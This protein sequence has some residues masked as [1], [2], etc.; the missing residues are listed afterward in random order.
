MVKRGDLIWMTVFLIITSFLVVPNLRTQFIMTTTNHPY[1]MGFAKFAIMASMGELLSIRIISKKWIVPTGMIYKAIVWGFVGILIVL[2]FGLFSEGVIGI[3]KKGLIFSTSGFA[4]KLLQAFSN[5][6][7]MNLTF[8]PVFMAAHRISDTWI[9]LRA[10][11]KDTSFSMVIDKINWQEFIRFVVC[12]TIPFLW[13][14]AHTITFMLSA[15][16]RVIMAAYLSIVLGLIL[17]YAR[18]RKN[19]NN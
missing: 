4:G 3:E 18:R 1:L 12:K 16:Y 7:L 6:V 5:S 14:P 9:D 19:V 2:M 10:V 8:A 13:I 17:A 15:Q 11:N